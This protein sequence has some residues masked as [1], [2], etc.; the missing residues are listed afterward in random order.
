MTRIT[1]DPRKTRE[2]ERRIRVIGERNFMDFIESE[3]P[4]WVPRIL[5][6]WVTYRTYVLIWSG[7]EYAL[8]EYC[9]GNQ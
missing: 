2:A 7:W 9:D 5:W 1:I 8:P 6:V 3:R 4:W